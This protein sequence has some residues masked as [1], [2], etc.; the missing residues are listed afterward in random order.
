MNPAIDSTGEQLAFLTA[1]FV[2]CCTGHNS[3]RLTAEKSVCASPYLN[4]ANRSNQ[5][6]YAERKVL[7][8]LIMEKLCGH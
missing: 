4:D 6:R 3:L 2:C 7:V 8:R 1:W 5:E